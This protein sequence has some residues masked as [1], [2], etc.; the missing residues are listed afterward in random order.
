MKVAKIQKNKIFE[1]AKKIATTNNETQQ[2]KLICKLSKYIAENFK[3]N[4]SKVIDEAIS[5]STQENQKIAEILINGINLEIEH[6]LFEDDNGN[7]FNSTMQILP[8]VIITE[9]QKI[10]IPSINFLKKLSEKIFLK[11]T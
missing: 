4:N 1:I 8:C 5:L 2:E 10:E 11:K 3:K 6:V 9:H 7:C